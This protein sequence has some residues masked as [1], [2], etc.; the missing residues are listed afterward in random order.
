LTSA[1]V[2]SQTFRVRLRV[3]NPNDRALPIKMIDYKLFLEGDSFAEGQSAAPF[4]V[5]AKDDLEFDM[6]IRTHFISSIGRLLSHIAGTD[7]TQIEYVFS[8]SVTVDMPFSPK[9]KFNEGGV[10][11]LRKR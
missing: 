11:D 2:F 9:I 10:V 8:G 6:P 3:E 7:R 1:D 4:V 5:P